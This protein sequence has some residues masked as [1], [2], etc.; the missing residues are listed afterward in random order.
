M[1][2]TSVTITLISL[3]EFVLCIS[4]T[5]GQSN[6]T[7]FIAANPPDNL[8]NVINGDT[9]AN[10]E[11]VNPDCVFALKHVSAVETTY[12]IAEEIQSVI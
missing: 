8:N 6:D 1:K 7:L 4:V 10:G 9:T 12:Y 2:I 11:W 5:F 3:I